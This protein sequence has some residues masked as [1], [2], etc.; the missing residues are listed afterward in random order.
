[1]KK[2]TGG[3]N[4]FTDKYLKLSKENCHLFPDILQSL[5]FVLC[6][7]S[8]LTVPG[9]KATA[10]RQISITEFIQALTGQ[11]KDDHNLLV[12]IVYRVFSYTVSD[13]N[14]IFSPGI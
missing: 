8:Y 11:Q 14:R 5:Q 6:Y 2:I 3:Q 7:A 12:K 4:E 10:I 13:P 1:M 9:F